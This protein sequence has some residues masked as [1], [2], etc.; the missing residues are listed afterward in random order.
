MFPCSFF[1]CRSAAAAFLAAAGLPWRLLE[2][3]FVGEISLLKFDSKALFLAAA[4]AFFS[5]SWTPLES[6]FA[7]EISL[8]KFDFRKS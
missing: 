3:Y 2:S 1:S 4:A 5:R 8:L 7:G 6:Y